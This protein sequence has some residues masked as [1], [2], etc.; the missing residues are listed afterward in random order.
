[1]APDRPAPRPDAEAAIARA[2]EAQRRAVLAC[3]AAELARSQAARLREHF[4]TYRRPG[5][6]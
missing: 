6:S 3:L 5:R 1:M 2:M 4:R